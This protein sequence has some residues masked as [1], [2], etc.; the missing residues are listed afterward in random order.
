MAVNIRIVL[1]LSFIILY[2]WKHIF[3]LFYCYCSAFL[4]QKSQPYQTDERPKS[5]QE[6]RDSKFGI[7][8]HWGLLYAMSLPANGLWPI[9]IW[10]IKNMLSWRVFLLI[11]VWCSPRVSAIKA[12]GAKYI[13]FTT[14]HHEGF[15]CSIPAIPIT[16]LWMLLLSNA[17]YWRSW[18]MNGYKQGIR[19]HLY[20]SHIDWFREDAPW[21]VQTWY[22]D[23]QPERR[24]EQLLQ[25]HE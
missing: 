15:S 25:L 7:F 10:I 16:I 3:Y 14:R 9:R 8:L 24:L 12:S 21:D 23:G 19:L 6:F 17:T 13:C 18:R 2:P 4:P 20:Y 5:R 1:Y 11:Q 22:R